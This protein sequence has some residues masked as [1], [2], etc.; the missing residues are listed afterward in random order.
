M[1][2]NGKFHNSFI[3]TPYI[4]AWIESQWGQFSYFCKVVKMSSL[5]LTTSEKAILSDVEAA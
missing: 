1:Q 4:S 2:V 5:F 3:S